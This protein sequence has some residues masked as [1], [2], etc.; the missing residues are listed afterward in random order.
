MRW[1]SFPSP[2]KPPAATRAPSAQ[3]S[4]LITSPGSA[5]SVLARRA[6]VH[7]SRSGGRDLYRLE[8]SLTPFA[9]VHLASA[10]PASPGISESARRPADPSPERSI[11]RV[12]RSETIGAGFMRAAASVGRALRYPGKGNYPNFRDHT[13]PSGSR[14][15][16]V[17]LPWPRALGM[18][19]VSEWAIPPHDVRPLGY[20][21]MS[22]LS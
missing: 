2:S 10:G 16:M 3:K 21:P 17:S 6:A 22:M 4:I 18:S 15:P 8:L 5:F 1:G 14:V 19:V 12:K 9:R 11:P 7:G 20:N 13:I